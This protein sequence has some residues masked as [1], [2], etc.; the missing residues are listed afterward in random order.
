MKQDKLSKGGSGRGKEACQGVGHC[1]GNGKED[2]LC[3]GGVLVIP[4]IK[5]KSANLVR[6]VGR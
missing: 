2:K 6:V 4:L 3:M 5:R 1:V